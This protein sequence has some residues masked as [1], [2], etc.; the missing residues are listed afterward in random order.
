MVTGTGLVLKTGT[1]TA[2]PNLQILKL[3]PSYDED[4]CIMNMCVHVWIQL[5]FIHLLNTVRIWNF[6]PIGSEQTTG[7]FTLVKYEWNDLD[8]ALDHDQDKNLALGMRLDAVVRELYNK[9]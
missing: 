3:Y 7:G 8:L 2:Q 6:W 4:G 5:N 1:R 9:K